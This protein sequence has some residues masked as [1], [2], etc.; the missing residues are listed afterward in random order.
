MRR[1]SRTVPILIMIACI[2]SLTIG[3]AAFSNTLTISSQ[4]NLTPDA[5][6]FDVAFSTEEISVSYGF[7]EKMMMN[8][9]TGEITQLENTTAEVKEGVDSV[10]G[11]T[12]TFN[13][14]GYSVNYYFGIHNIGKYTAYLNEIEFGNVSGE[15]VPKK[16][17]SA[18][19]TSN[20]SVDAAC[21]DIYV[22]VSWAD[23]ST[24]ESIYNDELGTDDV[25]TVLDPGEK[26]DGGI[27]VTITYEEGGA[28]ADE[29]FI[30]QFGSISFLFETID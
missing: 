4:A 3:F 15:S 22:E 8:L 23:C 21:D 29:D 24:R 12:A 9:S 2:L 14:P 27:N 26:F 16:C 19:G 25:C 1:R 6:G 10:S 18:S 30:V 20:A 17:T 11:F 28:R 7:M 5:S 13:E